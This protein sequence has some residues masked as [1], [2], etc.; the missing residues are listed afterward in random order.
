MAESEN[1]PMSLNDEVSDDKSE[2]TD[3]ATRETAEQPALPGDAFRPYCR[4][5]NCLMTAYKSGGKVTRY[6]CQVPGC[7]ES[8]KRARQR[9]VV[10]N[11]PLECPQCRQR[12]VEAAQAS[13]V[14]TKKSPD[15]VYCEVQFTTSRGGMLHMVCP[16][17][18][19]DFSVHV[20]RPDIA[21]VSQEIRRRSESI[22]AR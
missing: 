2:V 9:S 18:G 16:T 20:P 6:K 8:A 13:G 5:H 12:A 7:K 1:K 14:K 21:V 10:P 3:G 4:T 15:P 19:C 17:D 11:K 22:A